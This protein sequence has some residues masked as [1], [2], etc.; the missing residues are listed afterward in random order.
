MVATPLAT[1]NPYIPL[2]IRKFY[3]VPT[4]ANT[5]SPSRGEL[6]A[7]T[8]LSPQVT[9]ANGWSISGTTVASQSFVGTAIN[10][11]GPKSIDD[12]SLTTRLS[13]T[14]TDARTILTQDLAGYI[15]VFPEGDVTG[16]KMDV[17]TV[18]V[19]AIPKSP[20]IA[21]PATATFQF[22]I[23]ALPNMRVTIP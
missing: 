12:S 8:D 6:D 21:D 11:Q 23:T 19:N 5:A 13:K 4:I 1:L 20:G 15:V 14:T 22:A 3:W 10:L 16:R 18:I 9:D 17:F 2:D 7:G